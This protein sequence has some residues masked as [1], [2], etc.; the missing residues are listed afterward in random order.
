MKN[1]N[2]VF[3]VLIFACLAA[4]FITGWTIK[5]C[6]SGSDYVFYEPGGVVRIH[7]TIKTRAV[8]Y[9][10][11]PG[12][13][14]NVDSIVESVNRAWKDSLKSLFGKGLFEAK[15]VKEDGFGKR[16]VTLESRIPVDPEAEITLDEQLKLP[17]VYPKR[18]FGI[19]GGLAYEMKPGFAGT[20]GLK[21]Y[22]L[23]FRHLSVSCSAEGTFP[24]V[25]AGQGGCYTNTWDPKLKLLAELSF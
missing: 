9:R 11:I 3:Y 6:T 5:Q 1:N 17:E 23:D 14:Y 19:F 21:Y 15:F 2:F 7:D 20:I 13:S 16:E 12:R 10:I 25:K 18:T 4:G 24:L 22:L 8:E